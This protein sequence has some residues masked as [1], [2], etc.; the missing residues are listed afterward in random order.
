MADCMCR[1]PFP[2]N[3]RELANIMERLAVLSPNEIIDVED[4]PLHIRQ[5]E[6]QM[7]CL[8]PEENWNLAQAVK[9]VEAELIMRALGEYGSQRE[10]ARYLGIHHTTLSRKAQRYGISVEK[11][12]RILK[13]APV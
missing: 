9:Q 13:N 4:L 2:G 8:Q 7:T 3:V 11:T 6:N 12:H 10:A 5:I 1:Y